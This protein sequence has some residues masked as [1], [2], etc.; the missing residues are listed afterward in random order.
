MKKHVLIIVTLLA[1]S[2]VLIACQSAGEEPTTSPTVEAPAE[3]PTEEP[4]AEEPTE[5]P[6]EEPTEAPAAEEPTEEPM[7]EATEE[8]AT[9]EPATEEPEED[10]TA[11]CPPGDVELNIVYPGRLGPSVPVAVETMQESYPGLT[12]NLSDASS[13][14][15]D[16][17]QQVVADTAAGAAPDVVMASLGQVGFYAERLG[18]Q[19]IDTS[20]LSDTYDERYLEAGTIDGTVYAIPTQISIPLIIWNQDI[21][22]QAGLDPEAPPQTIPEMVAYAEQIQEQAPD[23]VPTFLPTSIVYDWIF[24]NMVQSAGGSIADENGQPAFNS[25]AGLAALQPWSVLN[26]NGLGL[27]IAGL[28]GFGAFHEGQVGMAF[29]ASSQIGGHTGAIGDAFAWSVAPM[30][31]PEGGEPR[32]AAGGNSWV[33]LTDE[34]C[35]AQYAQEFIAAT[36]TPATQAEFA[37]VTGYIPVDEE[38]REILSDFYAE[39]PNFAVSANYDGELTPW[40]SFSGEHAFEASEEFR[41]LLESVASGA[42]PAEAL[43]E[44]EAAIEEILARD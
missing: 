35:R 44:T 5:E 12:F 33:V 20:I 39:N 30:P 22:E 40:L 32:F 31:V 38:A 4:V 2:L 3:E 28:D 6:M 14:Y 43:A 24:Q 7:E 18:A 9:E 21:F 17:L 13:S 42:D 26:Q 37:Q 16:T 1:L 27:G 19:P 29:T 36:V 11:S 10:I 15:V 8:P 23:V 34:P 25:E 41:T